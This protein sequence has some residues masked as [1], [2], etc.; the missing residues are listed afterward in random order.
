MDSKL[1][2]WIKRDQFRRNCGASVNLS[3]KHK[4]TLEPVCNLPFE[5]VPMCGCDPGS[6]PIISKQQMLECE[7]HGGPC[8]PTYYERNPKAREPNYKI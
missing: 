8:S 1:L 5:R 3:Q 6:G 4:G 2:K 7:L